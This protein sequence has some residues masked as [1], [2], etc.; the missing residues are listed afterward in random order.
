VIVLKA[1][2]HE[3]QVMEIKA[4]LAHQGIEVSESDIKRLAWGPEAI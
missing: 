4:A 3:I 1:V 2:E